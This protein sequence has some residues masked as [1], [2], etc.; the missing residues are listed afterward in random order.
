MKSRGYTRYMMASL[1]FLVFFLS[2]LPPDAQ[3]AQAFAPGDLPPEP[4]SD[5]L[6][7]LEDGEDL[8]FCAEWNPEFVYRGH[9]CCAKA[10]PRKKRRG[11][12]CDP[13]R[14]RSNYCHEMTEDQHF[15]RDVLLADSNIDVLQLVESD[16]GIKG[17]QSYCSVNN[18]F[19]AWGRQLIPN[20]R[21]RI[22][23][24][25]PDRCVDFG[26]DRMIGMIEWVGRRVAERYYAPEFEKVRLVVGDISAPRGGCLAGRSGRRGHASHTSGLDVDF[27][28][29]VEKKPAPNTFTREFDAKA[30]WWLLKQLFQNP[31]A[32]IK[33]VFLD[34]RLIRKLAKAAKDDPMW[35]VLR[36][37]IRH[38]KF[39][40]NH[41][42][43][44]IG[45]HA[46]PPGCEADA[47]PE[48]EAN[49]EENTDYDG[50]S[51]LLEWMEARPTS[52][53]RI[54]P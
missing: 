22:H 21:N 25:S 24:K 8:G 14:T 35:P 19:L 32:C 41:H 13:K 50:F 29:L 43:V 16:L 10:K 2:V 52:T 44:R 7:V 39:H 40:R 26:T 49:I 45:P 30:N 9:H 18:G 20:S 42:H 3:A 23:L 15:Y 12:W 27:G 53:L 11:S 6:E 17:R 4:S 31:Y 48:L 37:F 38:V 54:D 28:F 33:V 36:R 46:G 5:Y 47:N 51:D 34:R 1:P